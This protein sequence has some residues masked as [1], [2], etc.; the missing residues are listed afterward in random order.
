MKRLGGMIFVGFLLLGSPWEGGS[1][2]ASVKVV[3]QF[4]PADQGHLPSGWR[5]LNTRKARGIYRVRMEGGN[6]YLEAHTR[7]EAVQIGKEFSVDPH[8]WPYLTWRWRVHR[9]PVG[10][11]ERIR[12]RNDS[13]AGVYVVFRRGWPSPLRHTLKYV[14]SASKGLKGKTLRGLVNPNSFY[15]VL[16][17]AT[18]PRNQ[19]IQETVNVLEDYR[20]LF[21]KD[22]PEVLGIGVLTDGDNTQSEAWADYDDFVFRA[23]ET[24]SSAASP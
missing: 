10:G 21:H 2:G 16:E 9:L 19:W 20:R 6:A 7:G 8:Q 3:E 5:A 15:I 24:A 17:D 18:S 1:W 12:D 23:A 13:A 22:P 11:D 4:S 14:W